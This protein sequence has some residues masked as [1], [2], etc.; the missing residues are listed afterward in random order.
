MIRSLRRRE[1]CG[2]LPRAARSAFLFEILRGRDDLRP[3]FGPELFNRDK[4]TQTTLEDIQGMR[5][6]DARANLQMHRVSETSTRGSVISKIRIGSVLF[7][8]LGGGV[9]RTL[10]NRKWQPTLIDDLAQKKSRRIAHFKAARSEH[11][12]GLRFQKVVHTGS[13]YMPFIAIL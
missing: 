9:A 10:A 7:E 11:R 6:A 2:L 12:A 1:L 3:T 13:D 5:Y 4:V 8:L